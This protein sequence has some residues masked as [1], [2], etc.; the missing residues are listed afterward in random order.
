V[1]YRSRALEVLACWREVERALQG[2]DE[3]SVETDA[4]RNEAMHLRDEYQELIVAARR[5]DAPEL[6][7]FSLDIEPLA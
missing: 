4:L 7:P 6:P 5:N 2:V 3:G 1:P